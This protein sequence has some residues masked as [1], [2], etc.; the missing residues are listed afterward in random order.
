[1]RLNLLAPVGALTLVLAACTDAVAPT[2]PALRP[3]APSRIVNG[4]PTGNAYPSVGALLVDYDANGTIDGD[5][6]FCTGS[7]VAP[8]VF[9]TAGHCIVTP[10]TPPGTQFY[11]AFAPDLYAKGLKVI[12]AT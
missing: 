3:D 10:Y 2:T 12:A 11:V 5:D 7:L 8:N 4:T 6:L 9:L 1:M